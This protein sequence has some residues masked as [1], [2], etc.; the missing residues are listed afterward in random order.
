METNKLR[1]SFRETSGKGWARKLR[2]EGNIPCILYGHR[3]KPLAIT[4]NEHELRRVLSAQGETAIV[5]LAV[6]G[7]VSKE[8]NAI[9]KEIQHHPAT[10]KILH[11]DFQYVRKGQRL[12]LE[13]PVVLVGTAVGVKEMGGV[14]EHGPRVLAVRC[15]PKHIPE[16]IEIEVSELKIG[17]GIHVKDIA[18][19]HP[20]LEFLDDLKTTLAIVVPPKV[21]VEPTPVEEEEAEEPEVI[22]KGKEEA[23]EKPDEGKPDSEA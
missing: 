10:G 5:D 21:E 2:A 8:C 20:D 19:K 11:V 4:V 6:E 9:I 15:L 7:K 22:A 17:D 23:P 18:P 3:E 13:V 14:L 1:S 16:N 12:R